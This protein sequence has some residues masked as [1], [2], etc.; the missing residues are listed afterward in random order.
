MTP[1]AAT[2]ESVRTGA[3]FFFPGRP[4]G[5]PVYECVRW[6][7]VRGLYRRVWPDCHSDVARL[8]FE[9]AAEIILVREP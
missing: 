1:R 2:I 7:R 8:E 9:P 6:A 3:V 4:I 5:A